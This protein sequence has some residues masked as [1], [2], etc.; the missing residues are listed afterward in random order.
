MEPLWT[1][2]GELAMP[3]TV[4]A[5]ERDWKYRSLARRMVGLLPDAELVVVPGGHRLALESPA[6][7]AEALAR[8]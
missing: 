6:A 2:L 7:V 8:R 3:T 1:R 4:I 5:G